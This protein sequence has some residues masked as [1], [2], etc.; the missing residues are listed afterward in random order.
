IMMS[1]PTSRRAAVLTA[2]AFASS[3]L[4]ADGTPSAAEL[5]IAGHP[6]PPS[7]TTLDTITV[8]GQRADSL[9]APDVH[10]ARHALEHVPG[11]VDLVDADE[12][13][14][15]AART[16]KDVLDYTPGV[17]VQPKWGEDAR[18]SIRG[19]G[20]SRNFHLR[21]VAL[22][23]DGIPMNASDG[24]ADFQEIDPTA[25]EYSEVYKGANALRYGANALGGAIAF[26]SPT[27]RS[28][29]RVQVRVDGGGF[30]FWRGQLAGGGRS[31]D[32]D[33]FATGSWLENDGFR[34]HSD[35]ESRRGSVNVGWR[36]T[37]NAETRLYWFGA[38]IEQRL[39]GAVT[40]RA[41]LGNPKTAA[42]D[43][44]RLDYQR[45]INSWRVA[46]KTTVRFGDG[47]TL[48]FGGYLVEKQLIH[49]IFRYID[50]QNDDH[51]GFV[52]ASLE[53]QIGGHGNRFVIG[54]N[55]FTGTIDNQQFDNLPGGERGSLRAA[56][57]DRADNVTLYAENHFD[58]RPTLALV[59]GVQHVQ[60]RRER[61]D[62]FD[63]AP[64]TSGRQDY[65]FTSPK[66]GLLWQVAPTAQVFANVSRSAEAPSFGDLNY[67]DPVLADTRAQRATTVELGTRG[68]AGRL[69][70][71]VAVYRAELR[72]E[73]QFFELA[74]NRFQV[75]N[76]DDTVHQGV[77]LGFGW[78]V[79]QDLLAAG[80]RTT[81]KLAYA[82]N[83]FFF[84]D[85]PDW[86]DN[87]L[88]GAPRHYLRSELR[89]EHTAGFYVAPNLEW[90]PQGFDV[91]NANTVQTRHYALLGLRAGYEPAANW[92]LYVD[93]R[94]LADEEYIASASVMVPTNPAVFEPGDGFAVFAGIQMS[95]AR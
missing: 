36:L 53:G 85:D 31:G 46:S 78:R 32:F 19:S 41:A 86:G 55:L 15:T 69:V 10:E 91:D 52:R 59:A 14:D 33:A 48:E 72:N 70:W 92:S 5:Q 23:V 94:N 42:A 75:T 11:S 74:P 79:A 34:D 60:A 27:G 64:D 65:D 82:F 95:F 67:T 12:W 66:L 22:L 88:P 80:D 7:E 2:L 3:S 37:P 77:E 38:D 54:A 73:L 49:P 24:S 43:N 84:D 8:T 50:N 56:S 26:V 21:G 16:L 57:A 51:G 18:L 25:F 4:H 29:D 44:R 71:D 81:W 93:A 62:R 63:E 89:Y 58:L 90:V 40:R 20:L 6:Y 35:G 9:T 39:P 45:N 30:D 76:A 83:D 28:G 61:E 17:F 13:R 87:E 47:G 1:S 68:E